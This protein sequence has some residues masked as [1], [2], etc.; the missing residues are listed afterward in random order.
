MPKRSGAA[1]PH[2]RP[3]PSRRRSSPLSKRGAGSTLRGKDKTTNRPSRAS[4]M[5]NL[6]PSSEER[7]QPSSVPKSTPKNQSTEGGQPRADLRTSACN[8][9]R[10]N[11]KPARFFIQ[12][13]RRTIRRFF[14]FIPSFFL[15]IPPVYLYT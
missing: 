4:Q 6:A 2:R 11:L 12:K 7:P 8:S 10:E 3:P 9:I 1:P 5:G 15:T 13:N 14:F